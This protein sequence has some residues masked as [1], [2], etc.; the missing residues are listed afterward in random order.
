MIDIIDDRFGFI[1]D[2]CHWTTRQIY[3]LSLVQHKTQLKATNKSFKKRTKQ[4]PWLL[5]G[6]F[7]ASSCFLSLRITISV[8]SKPCPSKI[9]RVVMPLQ[10]LLSESSS[11]HHLHLLLQTASRI[12]WK[13]ANWLHQK[14]QIIA[15][16][17]VNLIASRMIGRCPCLITTYE[18]DWILMS[19]D[20]DQFLFYIKK[21]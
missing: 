17:I 5:P 12:A 4:Q 11:H 9:Y 10:Q 6:Q 15:S 8:M 3:S 20:V 13:T 21:K 1:I 18:Y 14:I 19:L 16:E 2:D 7:S